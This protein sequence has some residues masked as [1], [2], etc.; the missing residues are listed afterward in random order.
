MIDEESENV[1]FVVEDLENMMLFVF[2]DVAAAPAA[3]PLQLPKPSMRVGEGRVILSHFVL[4]STVC[5][6]AFHLS[7]YDPRLSKK[8]NFGLI[9][10]DL[11]TY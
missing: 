8:S 9:F 6:E 4:G 7:I 2:F 1:H 5:M 10:W 3:L 11:F